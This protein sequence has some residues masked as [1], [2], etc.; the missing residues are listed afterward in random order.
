MPFLAL[1]VCANDTTPAFLERYST[2][3]QL[4]ETGEPF[5]GRAHDFC[6]V[7]FHIRLAKMTQ[8]FLM[9]KIHVR[10]IRA[11]TSAPDEVTLVSMA[12]A[13]RT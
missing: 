13:D 12:A 5:N 11:S 7:S 8:F 1:P 9:L 3:G 6:P 4:K 2:S 10:Q